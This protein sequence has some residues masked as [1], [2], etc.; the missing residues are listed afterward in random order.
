MTIKHLVL[1]G[2]GAAGFTVYGALKCMHNNE[3]FLFENIK[4]IHAS[5]AGSII[6]G[7]LILT[8]N[9]NDLDNYILK[10]PWDKLINITPT[11]I[12][13]LW[14]KKGIFDIEMIKEILKP[15]LKSIDYN[16]N[17]TLKQLFEKT[18][19]DFYC[20][21]TNVNSDILETVSLSY[22]THPDLEL[23]KAICMSS[24]FPMMFEPICDNSNCF[25]DGGLLNNFPLNDCININK[26]TDE[27]LAIKIISNNQ[28]KL[29][30]NNTTLP[31]YLYAIIMKMYVLL[32][33][34]I[35]YPVIKNIINCKIENNSLSRWSLAVSDVSVREEY[36]NIGFES[37]KKFLEI[38]DY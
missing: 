8:Q 28:I 23:C 9:W 15:F 25:I 4:S 10:R 35:E 7:L 29:I 22:H 37:A 13:S 1:S 14:Q 2:G 31:L 11:A 16:E 26:N 27:I 17:I 6:G 12:L 20:Y 3:Y 5:S 33:K 18:N 38:M 32:N 21:T 34:N 24:A 36:I 19:I 30:E